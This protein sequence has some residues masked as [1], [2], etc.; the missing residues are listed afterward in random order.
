MT[1]Q[2]TCTCLLDPQIPLCLRWG[3][4]KFACEVQ[5]NRLQELRFDPDVIFWCE[6]L[7]TKL[8]GVP[9]TRCSKCSTIN[10]LTGTI[11]G[12]CH[13][14]FSQTN[15]SSSSVA[16]LSSPRLPH[17]SQRPIRTATRS[18]HGRTPPTPSA[19]ASRFPAAPC[20]VTSRAPS[21]MAV[22][23]VVEWWLII[24]EN[25]GILQCDGEALMYNSVST[26]II[27]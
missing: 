5:T 10:Y 1:Q 26:V 3:W 22:E 12:R 14:F 17:P 23:P 21:M 16:A 20:E 19:A 7:H 27:H 6:S 11:L 24:R 2:Q 13:S 8:L 25:G 18:A 4:M 9:W 15:N